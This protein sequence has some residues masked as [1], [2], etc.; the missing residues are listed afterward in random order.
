[1]SPWSGVALSGLAL[2]LS[3]PAQGQLDP[4]GAGRF[5]RPAP[6]SLPS[7]S[8]ELAEERF[9]VVGQEARLLPAGEVPAARHDGVSAHGVGALGS[10]PRRLAEVVGA[11]R[12][13]R[14]AAHAWGGHRAGVA[15]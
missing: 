2:T 6:F 11:D 8:A 14:W 10:V 15:V 7:R 4:Q 13:R 1:P 9:Q 5:M 3:P 12:D